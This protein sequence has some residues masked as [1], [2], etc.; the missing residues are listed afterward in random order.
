[1]GEGEKRERNI[2]AIRNKKQNKKQNQKAY[3]EQKNKSNKWILD[4]VYAVYDTLCYIKS[5][6]LFN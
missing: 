5:I 3:W 2:N 1:M 4:K 6:V